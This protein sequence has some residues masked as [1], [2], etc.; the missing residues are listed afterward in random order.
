MRVSSNNMVSRYVV[1]LND[2]YANQSKL[3]EQSDGNSLH[4]PSDDSVNYSK[5]LRYSNSNSENLQYQNNVDTGRSWMRTMQAQPRLW[6]TL[7]SRMQR[8][9]T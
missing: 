7:K 5:Y 4:R 1:Q 2:S 3:M 8:L 9:L 6:Q